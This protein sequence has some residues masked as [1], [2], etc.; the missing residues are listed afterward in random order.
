MRTKRVR[1]NRMRMRSKRKIRGGTPRSGRSRSPR[2]DASPGRSRSR[3]RSR[4]RRGRSPSMSPIRGRADI[5]SI[6]RDLTAGI[7]WM[8]TFKSKDGY[9]ED[10]PGPNLSFNLDP[11]KNVATTLVKKSLSTMWGAINLVKDLC[12]T[13]GKVQ[14]LIALGE[15]IV[16]YGKIV[17]AYLPTEKLSGKNRLRGK[18]T[19]EPNEYN[20]QINDYK[21]QIESIKS[22]MESIETKFGSRS[23]SEGM[24][25]YDNNANPQGVPVIN[26]ALVAK[27]YEEYSDDLTDIIS[28]M[29]SYIDTYCGIIFAGDKP[30]TPRLG[31][32]NIP[33]LVRT[34][35]NPLH[36][37]G[38]LSYKKQKKNKTKKGKKKKKKKKKCKCKSKPCKC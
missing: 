38:Q 31:S 33:A 5:W 13:S 30:S 4:S 6:K 34:I 24:P 1:T 23:N 20:K 36:S 28:E 3:S 11:I 17:V 19:P 18:V 9:T 8:S 10:T 26:S 14:N 2:R 27:K 21:K 32:I 12:L 29:H 25:G 22:K 35:S 15:Q 37:S 16:L 7:N